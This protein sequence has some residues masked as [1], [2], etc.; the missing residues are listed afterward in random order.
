MRKLVVLLASAGL[1]LGLTSSAQAGQFVTNTSTVALALGG[2]PGAPTSALP[3]TE[4]LV[5]L[6]NGSQGNPTLGHNILASATVWST[7]NFGPGTSLFTGVPLISNLKITVRNQNGFL[8]DG[9]LD[10]TPSTCVQNKLGGGGCIGPTFGGV[11]KL[12]GATIIHAGGG[13]IKLPVPLDKVGGLTPGGQLGS[14]TQVTLIGNNITA[15]N[16]PFISGAWKLTGITSNIISIPARGNVQGVGFTLQ[17]T[18]SETAMTPS[19]NGGYVSISMGAPYENHTVT[20]TGTNNLA[21]GAS[22]QAGNVTVIAPIRVATGNIAGNIPGSATL[23]FNFVP[24]P[25][26]VL[27]LVSGAVGLA[28]IGRRRMRK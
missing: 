10:G 24:E 12:S 28:I 18:S 26:T 1:L 17:R 14:T 19:T 15:E 4:A 22:S 20:V 9:F 5:A 7:V 2:L 27:L 6:N 8:Q 23:V 25:G 11:L 13:A 16:G 3:G 21:S